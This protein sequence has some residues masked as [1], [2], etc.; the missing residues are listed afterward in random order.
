MPVQPYLN[1]NGRCDEAIEFYKSALGAKVNMLMRFK[2]MPEPR[3]PKM[4]PAMANKVMHSSLEIGGSTVLMSD[5]NGEGQPKFAG[6][7]LTLL[8]NTDAEAKRAFDA[9]AKDGKVG[10]ALAK[11]FFSSSFGMLNDRFGLS[12]MVFVEAKSSH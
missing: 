11:T 10:M 7:S 12:W 9:L 6:I 1:F 5:G 3:D 8:V 4:N 2:D